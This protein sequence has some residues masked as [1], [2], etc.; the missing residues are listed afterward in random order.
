MLQ[1][2]R[3]LDSILNVELVVTLRWLNLGPESELGL[4]SYGLG[5]G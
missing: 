3:A 4:D 2:G 5:L 1:H